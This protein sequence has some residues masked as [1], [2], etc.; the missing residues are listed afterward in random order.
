MHVHMCSTIQDSHDGNSTETRTFRAASCDVTLL[1][2]T[3]FSTLMALHSAAL[4]SMAPH[5]ALRSMDPYSVALHGLALHVR[6]SISVAPHSLHFPG[7]A[8]SK[9]RLM[10]SMS[11][12]SRAVPGE[13]G[14]AAASSSMPSLN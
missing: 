14:F 3:S 4:C 2:T 11:E 12:H 13:S 5:M 9:G 7:M 10:F 8:Q 6:A 1:S